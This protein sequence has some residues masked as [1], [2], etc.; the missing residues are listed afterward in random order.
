MFGSEV[1]SEVIVSELLALPAVTAVVGNRIF[2]MM[3]APDV[4]APWC[5]CYAESGIYEGPFTGV[6]NHEQLRYCV[7]FTCEGMSVDPIWP[8]AEAAF[9]K[10]EQFEKSNHASLGGT[11]QVSTIVTGEFPVTTVYE[12]DKFYRQLG[13]YV[14][15][16][17]FTGG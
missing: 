16:D 6:A 7:K 5:L 15:A 9:Q 1:A 11:Y 3:F 8:A 14:Q 17:V 4:S 13:F 2:G 10:F 12:R